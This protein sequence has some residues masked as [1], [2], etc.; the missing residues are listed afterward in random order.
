MHLWD[1]RQGKSI[2]SVFGL[3]VAGD[4]IDYR[5]GQ[6]L[7]GCYA[8]KNQIQI[9]DFNKFTLKEGINWASSEDKDKVAY[10][11]SSSFGYFCD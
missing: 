4:S 2:K 10:V 1:I 5:N 9:W 6:L 11:Y 3:H 7:I 8:A